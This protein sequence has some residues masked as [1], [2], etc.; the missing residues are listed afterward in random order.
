MG[1]VCTSAEDTLCLIMISKSQR[2][3]C[4][5][6]G[7][8][9]F[10]GSND[11]HKLYNVHPK[12]LMMYMHTG[13]CPDNVCNG[14]YMF[15]ETRIAHHLTTIG[16]GGGMVYGVDGLVNKRNIYVYLYLE[17]LNST[18]YLSTCKCSEWTPWNDCV[19]RTLTKIM[20]CLHLSWPKLNY[21][22]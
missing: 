20:Q 7:L 3:V 2:Q 4:D 16:G 9:K 17:L 12:L 1:E 15:W 13:A 11:K 19:Q 10:I 6:F 22:R 18:R 21:S 14:G 8:N 5:I